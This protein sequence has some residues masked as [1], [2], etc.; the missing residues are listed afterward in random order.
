MTQPAAL[1]TLR[2][3]AI[4]GGGA[5]LAYLIHMP[6]W[7]L[8]GPAILVSAASLTGLRCDLDTRL[9]DFVFLFI[10]IGVGAGVDADLR[11][12]LVTWPVAFLALSAAIF[13]MLILG[14]ALLTRFYGFDRRNALLATTPGHLSFVLGLSAEAGLDVATISIV[15]TIRLLALTLTVPFAAQGFGVELGPDILPAGPPM[16]VANTLILLALSAA[17]GFILR[18]LKVPAAFVIGA[19]IVSGSVHVTGLIDGRLS[20][21]IALA[22][23]VFM[24]ALIGTRF[25]GVTPARLRAALGA[26]LTSTLLAAG[27]AIAAALPVAWGL[28]LDPVHVIVAFSPGGLETMIA[29][30]AVLGADPGFV[31]GAH[32]VRLLILPVLV[33]LL[34]GRRRGPESA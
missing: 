29:M 1:V 28:G 27:I 23:F 13:A 20:P 34:L 14:R 6:V 4:G 15:Q 17:L 31:A 11:A 8:T 25:S 30:G 12:A 21:P 33:P 3:L 2:T 24:G 10:G 5:G 7:V 16:S 19:M 9:R 22:A 32:V 18:H 26:G